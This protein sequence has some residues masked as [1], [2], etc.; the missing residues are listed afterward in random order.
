[1]WEFSRRDWARVCGWG[2]VPGVGQGGGTGQVNRGWGGSSEGL[3]RASVL[4]ANYPNYPATCGLTQVGS[5]LGHFLNTGQL[6]DGYA[7]P[8]S[9]PRT[10]SQGDRLLPSQALRGKK[11]PYSGLGLPFGASVF[12]SVDGSD[13]AALWHLAPQRGL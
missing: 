8:P 3:V 9:K 2:G 5:N 10:S 11:A 12:P 7:P 1:M 6:G 4:Y 13:R